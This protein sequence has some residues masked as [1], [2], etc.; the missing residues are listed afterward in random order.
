MPNGET[1][2]LVKILEVL[3]S[4]IIGTYN[5]ILE[6]PLLFTLSF[7]AAIFP[8]LI[9]LYIFSKKNEKSKKTVALIFFLGT[10]TA[11]ALLL[12]QE[13]WA[14]F[15]DFNI[16]S[17]IEENITAQNTRFILMFLLFAAMEEIIK[18]YV[19]KIIDK[20]TIL[21]SSINDA[22]RYS[23]VSAL[24][25]SFAENIYY[26]VQYNLGRLSLAEVT[27]GGLAGLYIF[28][29]VFTMCAHMIFS[30]VF[31]YF[32]GIGKFSILI[33]EEQKITGQKSPMAKIIAKM[34]NLPLSEGFR[35]KLILRGLATAITMHVIFNYLLQFNITIPV[36][37]FVVLGY[38]YL[39]YLL[40]RKTG[41]LVLLADPTTQ[42]VSTMAKRDEDVV[43]ELIGMWFN[44]K[45]YV[46]VIHICE[47]LL[48]RDPDNQVVALFKA[49]AMDKMND[50]DT[51]KQVLG[52]VLK[53]KN[54]LSA[55]DQNII[56]RHI[57][58]KENRQK[59]QIRMLQQMEKEGK[60]IPQPSEKKEISD[61]KEKGLLESYTGEGTFKI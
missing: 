28:R 13:Y 31:G 6:N 12:L 19:I 9:W 38:F 34:F 61:K 52:T 39:Q 51:Y 36:I 27:L 57:S 48:E 40:K 18:F 20:K 23:L 4:S 50:K 46:D 10:L 41:H 35:Q 59:E 49:K 55:D 1:N 7:L 43:I 2:I 45:R 3:Q 5:F 33:N 42:R 47:R 53:S 22:L 58:E 24:G 54:D 17:L 26:L 11:P 8:V 14:A 16:A 30:G 56:S 32:Y 15:P 44:E 21:I 29:S 37:I 60:K 25:F